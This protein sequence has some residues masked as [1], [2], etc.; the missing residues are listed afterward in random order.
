MLKWLGTGLCAR[1]L[2]GLLSPH[3]KR[4]TLSCTFHTQVSLSPWGRSLWCSGPVAPLDSSQL[5]QGHV[6]CIQDECSWVGHATTSLASTQTANVWSI[7]R[8]WAAVMGSDEAVEDG[9]ITVCDGPPGYHVDCICIVPWRSISYPPLAA[10]PSNPLGGGTHLNKA[11]KAN[12]K[13][14]YMYVSF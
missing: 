2:A 14:A 5:S 12:Q 3:S 13:P 6:C 9:T 7:D 10:R 8:Q 1:C 4:H 11:S